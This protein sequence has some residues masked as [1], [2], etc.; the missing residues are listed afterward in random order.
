M[1][2]FSNLKTDFE[3]YFKILDPFVNGKANTT[4]DK[5]QQDAFRFLY[6]RC[7]FE[8]AGNL[9]TIALCSRALV[10]QL[11]KSCHAIESM[12]SDDPFRIEITQAIESVAQRITQLEK[13]KVKK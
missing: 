12:R 9:D 11:E 7:L 6:L 2:G 10:E 8:I 13:P 4:I 1:G 3:Q 5:Q